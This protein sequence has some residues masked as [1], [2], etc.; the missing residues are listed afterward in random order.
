MIVTGFKLNNI[1]MPSINQAKKVMRTLSNQT[2]FCFA[3]RVLQAYLEALLDLFFLP[4]RFPT[5]FLFKL[6]RHFCI[7]SFQPFFN[8]SNHS[9]IQSFQS[10]FH[11]INPII[12]SFNLSNHSFIQ[13][14]Q[15]FFHSI[16]LSF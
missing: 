9:F 3:R 15:S 16:I 10:F 5:I 11:S 14:F 2:F 6:S 13:S 1:W 4:Q 12:L 7:L 8:L